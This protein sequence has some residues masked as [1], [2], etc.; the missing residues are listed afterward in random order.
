VT[1]GWPWDEDDG[2]PTRCHVVLPGLPAGRNVAVCARGERGV[3]MTRLN[4]GDTVAAR[5]IVRAFNDSLGID[6]AAE[7]AM[8][9]GC[10]IGWDSELADP[11]FLRARRTGVSWAWACQRAW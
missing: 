9:A 6:A 1:I 3:R 4:L 5:R 2:L 7:H 10:L 11:A 8:L